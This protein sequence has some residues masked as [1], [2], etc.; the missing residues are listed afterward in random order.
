MLLDVLMENSKGEEFLINGKLWQN[1]E[2]VR[3]GLRQPFMYIENALEEKFAEQLYD[4]LVSFTGWRD[5]SYRTANYG[6]AMGRLREFNYHR[7]QISMNAAN[8]PTLLRALY[9]FLNSHKTL[10]WI[11]DVSGRRC[12]EFGGA[13]AAYDVGDSLDEHN[14]QSTFQD[15]DG[16]IVTRAVTFNY[17][18]TRHWSKEWGGRFIW[19]KPRQEFVPAFNTLLLFRVGEDTLHKV[20][21]ILDGA[22]QRRYS[23]TGWFVTKRAPAELEKKA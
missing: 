5:E 2:G 7:K 14:D 22:Q 10:E 4:E 18:L 9:Q 13:A 16:N 17:F 1:R 3:I 21:P 11:S 20:E 8:A 19:S 12:D 23:I 6:K 15:K